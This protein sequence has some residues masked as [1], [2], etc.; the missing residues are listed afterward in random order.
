MA[1][2]KE[3]LKQSQDKMS[4]V[5]AK[6][7]DAAETAQI[8]GELTKD[9]LN[10]RINDIKGDIA[11]SKENANLAAERSKSKFNSELI[12]AQMTLEAAKTAVTEKKEAHE[13]AT[14]EKRIIELLDYSDEC[15][16]LAIL[17]TAEANLALLEATA[18]SID[19][20]E[21]YDK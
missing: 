9:K 16:R 2:F 3:R 19:Y 8:A 6:I 21:K 12:K 4:E 14:H 17:L 11:A 20:A 10:E 13:K 7:N 18:E 15:Q 1:D 5:K